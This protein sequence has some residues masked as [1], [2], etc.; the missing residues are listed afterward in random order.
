[1]RKQPK[2]SPIFLRKSTDFAIKVYSEVLKIPVGTVKTYKEIAVAIKCPKACRAVGSA[3][4]KNPFP[5]LIPCHRVIRSN[6]D[7]GKY[8]YGRK[9]KEKL[10]QAERQF[11]DASR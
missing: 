4:R 8:I 10:I 2:K 11:F 9:L 3:L 1:M 6:G 5:F 7:V